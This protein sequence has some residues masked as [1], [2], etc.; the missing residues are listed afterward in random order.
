MDKS[1][2]TCRKQF[3]GPVVLGNL[4]TPPEINSVS[5]TSFPAPN[6]ILRFMFREAAFANPTGSEPHSSVY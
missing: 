4:S 5:Q 3:E 2:R 1:L 6:S